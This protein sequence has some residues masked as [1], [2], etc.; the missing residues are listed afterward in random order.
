MRSNR[1][2]QFSQNSV[3]MAKL[4]NQKF[5]DLMRNKHTLEV[6]KQRSP[7][8]NPGKTHSPQRKLPQLKQRWVSIDHMDLQDLDASHQLKFQ[9]PSKT[10]L[11]SNFSL[12]CRQK[13][14]AAP[15]AARCSSLVN[16]TF[17]YSSNRST[18]S[19]SSEKRGTGR[20]RSPS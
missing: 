18:S 7:P 10:D 5:E 16:T 8:R 3:A 15:S 6:P 19:F 14:S 9:Q 12:H 13:I 1:N 2:A 11:P 4:M 20:R 17:V